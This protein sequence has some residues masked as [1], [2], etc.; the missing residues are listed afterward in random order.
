M[1]ELKK[2]AALS[3]VLFVLLVFTSSSLTANVSALVG[4]VPLRPEWIR[5]GDY[6]TY[7]ESVTAQGLT[8]SIHMRVTIQGDSGV[9]L[10]KMRIERF[11]PQIPPNFPSGFGI[12]DPQFAENTSDANF[13]IAEEKVATYKP[14]IEQIRGL[15]N[16]TYEAYKL[17]FHQIYDF[18]DPC[19]D[20]NLIVWYEKE[21][22]IKVRQLQW[23]D[24]YGMNMN[25]TT[26]QIIEDS[27]IQGLAASSPNITSTPAKTVTT[28][29]FVT[30]PKTIVTTTATVTVTT[31]VTGSKTVETTTITETRNTSDSTAAI[32]ISAGILLAGAVISITLLK[33]KVGPG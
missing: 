9:Y 4:F 20:C 10:N 2:G 12:L 19:R 17:T 21:T 6:V 30:P 24:D 13:M 33:R 31:T 26:E 16:K 14:E 23:S 5:E 28:T 29:I 1:I 7:L 11:E 25:V 15:N 27:N 22:L 8:G 3:L 18:G 32:P